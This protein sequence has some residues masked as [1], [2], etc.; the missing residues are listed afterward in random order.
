[1]TSMSG[2][3]A[4][5]TEVGSVLDSGWGVPIRI[6][7]IVVVAVL[8]R[9]VARALIRRSVDRIVAGV[10]RIQ[11]AEAKRLGAEPESPVLGARRIQRTRSLGRIFGN[12]STVAISLVAGLLIV[13]TAWPA[14]TTAFG[15]LGAGI[16]AGIGLGAQGIVR[17]VLNGIFFAVEDQLGIGDVVDAGFATGVVEDLGVR[18]TKVRD[19]NG[20]LWF[21]PNG[22]INRIGNQSHGWA[23]AVVDITVPVG[24]DVEAIREG[25]RAAA[26]SLAGDPAWADRILETPEVWGLT[27]VAVDS[28]VLREVV[29]TV[30]NAQDAVARE[31]RTRIKLELDRRGLYQ[32]GATTIAASATPA[33]AGAAAE[34]P[35]GPAPDD[36]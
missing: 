29:K 5:W 31:L 36:E 21:I 10:R 26:T 34:A 1:M 11:E 2:W 15:L 12:A 24:A 9:L 13:Y 28:M 19:V 22:Q 33:G 17:D 32:P 27:T 16:G 4:F 35:V 30:T 6:A 20:T 7:I 18:T 3:D 25:M 14:A 8:A 23:R